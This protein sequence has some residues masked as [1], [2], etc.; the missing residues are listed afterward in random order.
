[1]KRFLTPAVALLFAFPSALSAQTRTVTL[2]RS[3]GAG[4]AVVQVT[5]TVGPGLARP[6]ASAAPL[7]ALATWQPM[8]VPGGVYVRA[9]SMGTSQVGFAAGELGVV[10]KT[11]DGGSNWTTILNQGFPYYWY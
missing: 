5:P 7:S 4:T 6:A 10:L 11:I 2:T 8:S 1:M 9:I 3:T